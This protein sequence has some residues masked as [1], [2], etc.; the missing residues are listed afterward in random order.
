MRWLKR[1]WA[2]L[3]YRYCMTERYLAAHRGEMLVAVQWERSA[4]EWRQQWLTH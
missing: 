3:N 1:V 2:S 4:W